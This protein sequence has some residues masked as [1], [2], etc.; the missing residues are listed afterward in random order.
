MSKRIWV[1]GLLWLAAGCGVARAQSDL[2]PYVEHEKRLSASQMVSPLSSDL[3][4]DNISLYNG[5]TEFAVTDIDLPGNNGLPVQLRRRFKVESLK[6]VEPLG[7]FGAW[8]L[9]VPYMYG[10]FD[11]VYKWNEGAPGGTTRCSQNWVPK[12]QS[13][14]S[15]REIWHG[16][17]MHLPGQGD[18]EVVRNTGAV[19]NDGQTYTRAASDF[20]RFRC[21][22]TTTNGYPGEGFIAV[23]TNGTKYTF[24]VG[25]ERGAGVMKMPFATRGR[26]KVFLM[27]SRIEDRFGNWVNYQYTGDKLTA[28]NASDGRAISIAWNGNTIASATENGRTW[29]YG[30]TGGGG[31]MGLGRYPLV[32]DV[33]L[34]DG[35]HFTYQYQWDSPFGGLNTNYTPLDSDPAWC[36]APDFDANSFTLTAT[37]PSGAVGT[38]YLPYK[39]LHRSGTPKSACVRISDENYQLRT[40]DY[41][42][43]YSISTKTITGP[44]LPALTWTYTY[45]DGGYGRTTS[46]IPCWTNCTTS[47]WVQV[48]QPDGNRLQYRFGSLYA[49]NEGQLLETR[50]L[51]ADGTVMRTQSSTYVTDAEAA[52]MPFP[53][54]LGAL[55]GADDSGMAL[56]IRPV[57]QSATVQDGVTF[58]RNIETFDSFARPVRVTR[59]STLGY[60]RT[61]DTTYHDN[62]TQWALGQV[63]TVTQ[64]SPTP[65]VTV[66]QTDYDAASLPWKRYSF[67][68]LKQTLTY[69]TDGTL[70]TVKDGRNNTTT[71][72]SWMRGVPQS[73]LYASGNTQSA[74]VDDNGWIRSI[75]EENGYTTG[76]GY[77]AMGRLTLI[78]YPNG[79]T[80]NWND[81]ASMFEKVAAAEY[82]LPAGHWRHTVS[83]GNARKVTYYDALWRPVVE[84]QYDTANTAGT[85]S[86]TVKR[87]DAD[88]ANLA[89]QS[90]PIRNLSSFA[91]VTQ[92]TRTFYDALDRPDVVE[93]DSE[94]GMLTARTEYLPGFQV[95]VTNPRLQPTTTSFMAYDEPTMDWP[96]LIANPEGVFTDIA[97]DAF[98]KPTSLARRNAGSTIALTRRYVYDAYQRLCKAIEPETG[99]TVM[100]YD[101]A[102]NL[103][104]SAS[105]LSLTDPA[106]CNAA[107][108][109]AAASRAQRTYDVMNRLTGLAFSDGRGN[110]SLE[111]WADGALKKILTSNDGVVAT[112]EYAYNRRRLLTSESVSQ[113]GGETW[114]LGY[115]YDLNGNLASHTYPS[116]LGVSY[117]PNALGQPTQAGTYATGVTY[118]PNGAMAQFT[119][120]NGI[121]HTLAQNTRGLPDRSR[122]ANA[123]GVLDDSYDYDANG[124]V[125]AISDGLAGNRGDRT[126]AYDSL[127]RLVSTVSPMYGATGASYSYDVL[128]NL[129]RVVAP[130]RDHHYCYD[131]RWQL[132]NLKTGSCAGT[133]EGAMGYDARGN[134]EN[135]DG[136]TFDFD[137]GNRL[138]VAT[139]KESYRY[140]GH[141]RRIQATR[142]AGSIWSMYGM[143]GVLRRQRNELEAKSYEYIHL[144]G[145]LL[146]RVAAI[147]QPAVPVLQVSPT[148]TTS[149]DYTVSWNAVTGATGYELQESTDGGVTWQNVSFAG[150]TKAFT[151]RATGNYSYHV[152]ANNT[153][154][155][156]TWSGTSTVAVN[157]PPL[158]TLSIT[159]PATGSKG[160]Y[161]VSWT[162][163]GGATSYELRESANGGSTWSAVPNQD[164]N[165]LAEQF[166]GKPAGV[167]LYQYRACNS[168]GCTDYQTGANA[169]TV[170]YPPA[171]PTL[172]AVGTNYGGAYT[173]QWSAV[174]GA[175][176]YELEEQFNGGAPSV[177]HNAAASS[178]GV[179][180]R[181]NGV[182]TYQV[183]ACNVIGGCSSL[184]AP[185]S[186]TVVIKPAQPP[187]L[188]ASVSSSTSGSYAM[189]W[190]GVS[191]ATRY[192]VY[193]RLG[194]GG[195]ALIYNSSGGS[196]SVTNRGSGTWQ[197][198]V[199]ACNDAGCSSSASNVV[200]VTVLRAPTQAPTLSGPTSTSTG[201]YTVT[202]NAVTDAAT[203][204]LY[205]NTNGG[206]W[207]H[208][209]TN[210]VFSVGLVQQ[211]AGTYQYY[212]VGCNASGCGPA[213]NVLTVVNTTPPPPPK[214]TGL[215]AVY[216]ATTGLCKIS[217]NAS[218]GATYYDLKVSGSIVYSEP[219]TSYYWDAQCPSSIQ[220]RAC[221]ASAC[222]AWAP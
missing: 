100:A 103:D 221:N 49:G 92:G 105:G 181:V 54:T 114:A 163:V 170:Q 84:E 6:E 136:Q 26:V 58:S 193:E 62:T 44:G 60:S 2:A 178:V 20:Y 115:G 80:V 162:Q 148:S 112:N 66:A 17:F 186:V 32:S 68:Q 188:S 93:Q 222:S 213:S 142:A 130:G 89:F 147:S 177:I 166:N 158:G 141:G 3:F 73:I 219:Q 138:R 67:G 71:L 53:G 56:K 152:R 83:T 11:G 161:Q 121:I 180:G 202:W 30:Y 190:T 154:G 195:Y 28:I 50:T 183:K 91:T 169:V 99:A 90:Y 197:Y 42:D 88:S 74:V 174:S 131:A 184:S 194:S 185:M 21:K 218:A 116:G 14:F 13:P 187:T 41:F 201:T 211:P 171:T 137:F 5:A 70:A 128:D 51:A 200:T 82:G 156:G 120:G 113:T 216:S 48:L 212:V 198:I 159:V 45:G 19:P 69:Y 38:F 59:S 199:Y 214:P 81:T 10:T 125:A 18:R 77:D 37:H 164:G 24:D 220:V 95:R 64:I 40:A 210:P 78:D 86:Q 203:Y 12:T 75:T 206:G 36:D 215:K 101:D 23:D 25:I 107:E 106:N 43:L 94:L 205:I 168:V 209:W 65:T 96:V 57:R 173:V 134:V 207:V 87:Y 1:A 117:A 47:K 27:A 196:H 4:G 110:Q 123:N 16:N 104:W 39:R 179:S 34:P 153:A 157:R 63:A 35:S 109:Y 122:D 151:G 217:W 124:N 29:T 7:G 8:D 189:T 119:Y 52:T 118:H 139:G 150:M 133:T 55:T 61:E 129:T 111:Y 165:A 182:Y 145:S 135:K 85:L 126:M 172:T 46:P 15:L 175:S 31:A 146:A 76:Y 140:D 192:D 176:R 79:D 127:D 143:D 155:V 72:S 204:S 208:A 144:N 98:G 97:R 160:I 132:T 167:Y 9:D 191:F 102:G 22:S 33:G 108:G 149:G